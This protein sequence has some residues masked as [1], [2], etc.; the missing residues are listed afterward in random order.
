MGAMRNPARLAP[1]LVLATSASLMLGA[2]AFQYIGGLF[3]CPLC[4]FQRYPH[5][6]TIVLGVLALGHLLAGRNR[7]VPWLLGLAGLSL[8]AGAGIAVFHVGVEQHW[9][10]GLSSCAGP[11]AGASLADTLNQARAGPAA[12]CDEVAWS[13]LG[14]SMAGYNAL[15]SVAV[16][17]FAF[18]AA[19]RWLRAGR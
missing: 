3:P 12:R 11:G 8:L 18:W 2:L 4:I 14:I 1:A 6:I 13:L 16:G 9:W 15:I 5:V 10:Q 17:L 7:A 19:G